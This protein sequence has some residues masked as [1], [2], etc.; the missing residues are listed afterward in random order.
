MKEKLCLRFKRNYC[1]VKPVLRGHLWVK[2]KVIVLDKGPLKRG[3]I[4]MKF[5]MK[6][7]E[8]YDILIQVTA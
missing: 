1:T 4:H 2:E 6:G 8:N 5:T 7:Q 3:S